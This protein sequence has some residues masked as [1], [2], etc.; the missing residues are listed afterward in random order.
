MVSWVYVPRMKKL[1]LEK[2]KPEAGYFRRIFINH[3]ILPVDPTDKT[4]DLLSY[5]HR[6]ETLTKCSQPF[7]YRPLNKVGDNLKE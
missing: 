7:F 2:K 1:G 3:R 6:N 5:Q 4:I